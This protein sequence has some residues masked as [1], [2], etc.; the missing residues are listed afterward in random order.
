ME[1]LVRYSVWPEYPLYS[2]QTTVYGDL[3]FR[4]LIPHLSPCLAAIQ[5]YRQDTGVK[6]SHLRIFEVCVCVA[7]AA[8]TPVYSSCLGYLVLDV[9]RCSIVFCHLSFMRFLKMRFA[10]PFALCFP[11]CFPFLIEIVLEIS[12]GPL[13]S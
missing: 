10:P 1:L 6:D 11:V 2:P 9:H 3:R 8:E 7:Y 13:L 12:Y 5:E 4:D